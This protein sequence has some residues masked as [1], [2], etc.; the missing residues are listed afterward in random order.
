MMRAFSSPH[1]FS[2]L[3]S[4][5]VFGASSSMPSV[6]S[7]R[8]VRANSESIARMAPRYILRLTF[9]SKLRGFAANA[10][11]PPTQ[12]GLRLEPARAPPR[13]LLRPGLPAAAA[14]FCAGLLRLG[15]G[16]PR[17]AIR[18]DDLVNQGFVELLAERCIGNLQLATTIDQFECWHKLFV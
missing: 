11:P 9:C 8:S 14:D 12:I 13:P 16:A 5:R 15:A 1:C 7:R 6:T 17:V 10:R 2:W 3:T 4:R 18:S